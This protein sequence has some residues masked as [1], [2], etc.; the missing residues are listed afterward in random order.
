[1]KRKVASIFLAVSCVVSTMAGGVN[2]MAAEKPQSLCVSS[3]NYIMRKESTYVNRNN[4]T[5]E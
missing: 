2:V 4:L 5:K 3:Y 1:M